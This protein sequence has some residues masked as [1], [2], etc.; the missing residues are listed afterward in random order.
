M[1]VRLCCSR[2]MSKVRER[3]RERRSGTL[4][5][6]RMAW[7]GLF[8]SEGRIR[9]WGDEIEMFI[10]LVRSDVEKLLVWE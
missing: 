5:R 1:S 2:E 9:R 4:D 8:E 10:F 3:E 7:G 6:G